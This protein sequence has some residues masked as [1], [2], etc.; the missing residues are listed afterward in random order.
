MSRW[1]VVPFFALVSFAGPQI[2]RPAHP[3]VATYKISSS[4]ATKY[5]TFAVRSDGAVMTADW[6]PDADGHILT[7][8]AIELRDRY[9]VVEPMTQST[10]TYKPY[11]P[12]IA[13]LP[14]CGG[15]PDET[16][17]GYPTEVTQQGRTTRWLAVD[18][19]CV[20]LREHAVRDGRE[21]SREAISVTLGEPPAEYFQV[22]SG[23]QERGPA[24]LNLEFARKFPGQQLYDQVAVDKLQKIYERN[25]PD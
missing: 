16:I 22:P 5:R 6:L 11:K 17:L 12:M 19:N 18:L 15:T 24:D 3:F 1:I 4:R 8:R 21:V 10:S 2:S 14:D 7:A 13:A 9:V 23:Y 20:P 25:R